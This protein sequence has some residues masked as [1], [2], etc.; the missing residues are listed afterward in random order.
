M[1][2]MVQPANYSAFVV[3][4]CP[5]GARGEG[6]GAGDHCKCTDLI[7]SSLTHSGVFKEVDMD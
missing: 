3:I 4:M 5:W 2:G 6:G 7:S 1:C